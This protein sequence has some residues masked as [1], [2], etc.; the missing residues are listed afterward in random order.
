MHTLLDA[1][2]SVEQAI[3]IVANGCEK[4][5]LE[6]SVFGGLLSKICTGRSLSEAMASFRDKFSYAEI[7]VIRAAERVGQPQR[8]VE[9]LCDFSKTM[10]SIRRKI[11]SAMVYPCIVLTVALCVLSILSMVVIPQFQ[12][13]FFDQMH[14]GELPM[15]TRVVVAMCEFFREHI[16]LLLILLFGIFFCLKFLPKSQK[17]AIF[18]KLP[19]I[20][21][22]VREYNLY[23]FTGALSMLLLCN[24]QLQESLSIARNVT[25]GGDLS[26][27]LSRAVERINHGEPL[28]SSMAGILSNFA[29]GLILAGEHTG[30]LGASLAEVANLYRDNLTAKLATIVAAIEPLLIVALAVIVGTAIIALLLPMADVMQKIGM[31]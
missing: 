24:V 17:S 29:I 22:L 10:S 5:S 19:I 31:P 25:F 9:H 1:G 2:I 4:N 28:S 27:R 7:N 11:I 18:C 15:L 20:S 14:C 23:L 13:L 6:Y 21:S 12:A 26:R 8:A 3:S 16:F 30:S